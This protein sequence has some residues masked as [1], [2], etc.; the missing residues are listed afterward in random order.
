MTTADKL[1]KL[2]EEKELSQEECAKLLGIDRTTYAK[3]ENGGSIKRNVEKLASFF[4]VSTDYLLG[5][6]STTGTNDDIDGLSQFLL[7]N[8]FKDDPESRAKLKS[9][10]VNG[11]FSDAGITYP[12]SDE[13]LKLVEDAIRVAFKTGELK[14][15]ICVEIDE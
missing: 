10:K 8:L 9:I 7:E 14:G 15:R 6:E 5:R 3:Y 2:R 13:S 4:N 1:R 11:T 12:L